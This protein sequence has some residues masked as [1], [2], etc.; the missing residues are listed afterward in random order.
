MGADGVPARSETREAFWRGIVT[1]QPASGLS[2]R[3]WCERHEVSPPS[4][5]VW[6]REL[7][8]RDAERQTAI[9]GASPREFVELRLA[10]DAVAEPT[11]SP[12]QAALQIVVS[13]TRIEVG[14]GFDGETLKRLLGVLRET[15]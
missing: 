5:Y 11:C 1:G 13:G 2:I 14:A 8:R 7:A 15:S 9:D 12:R 6:R 10:R 3:Q 4:F